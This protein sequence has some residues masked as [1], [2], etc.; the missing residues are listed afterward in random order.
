MLKTSLVLVSMLLLSACHSLN[1]RHDTLAVQCDL[2]G[3]T[4]NRVLIRF[5]NPGGVEL[6]PEQVAQLKVQ[7]QGVSNQ[8]SLTL[9][10]RAC[11]ALPLG[12]AHI[13]A[14]ISGD[15]PL[16]AEIKL[17]ELAATDTIHT[18]ILEAPGV[19]DLELKCPKNG[20]LAASSLENA[21]NVKKSVGKLNGYQVDLDLYNSSNER[22][23]SLFNKALESE[24]LAIPQIFDLKNVEEGNYKV[25]LTVVD[26]Y[27]NK[28]GKAAES[29][30]NLTVRRSCAK[31]ETFDAATISCVP[32]LCD[33]AYRIGAKWTESLALQRGEGR[34]ECRL[35]KEKAHK[36][37]VSHTCQ[38]GYFK[39]A[40][41]CL[42]AREIAGNCALLETDEVVCWGTL[43]GK[44]NYPTNEDVNLQ[45][46]MKFPEKI[47]NF[48]KWCAEMESGKVHCWAL[49]YG[50]DKS[51]RFLPSAE[52]PKTWNAAI[53]GGFVD[54]DEPCDEPAS[55][56]TCKF[57]FTQSGGV[58]AIVP[59]PT[60][61]N[62]S[63]IV[64]IEGKIW[65]YQSNLPKAQPLGSTVTAAPFYR[66]E[67]LPLP[68]RQARSDGFTVCAVLIDGSV[69]CWGDNTTGS[70]GSNT[71][72]LMVN[73]PVYAVESK[74]KKLVDIQEL[75][76]NLDMS[77][78]R[79]TYALAKDGRVFAWGTNL[80][81]TLANG[82]PGEDDEGNPLFSRFAVPVIVDAIN[83]IIYQ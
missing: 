34:Y 79:I 21:V 57:R 49:T 10:S 74:G 31:D 80:E 36:T 14:N 58:N 28:T 37:L 7:Y 20:W 33:S 43:I 27:H 70:V 18:V 67:G 62:A 5:T 48:G 19:L 78:R 41:S 1:N 17:D 75:T 55:D 25:K 63:C 4:Q 52:T 9:T 16:T 76:S 81:G 40:D 23:Q 71:S 51:Y 24:N 64:D 66:V 47:K 35:E 44:E 26:S 46:T 42:G 29:Q 72:E 56:A 59:T 68:A 15:S 2:N 53:K 38:G 61:L 69:M 3:R 50:S 8:Q 54:K 60:G 82:T 32:K 11:V 12:E 13:K 6:T 30:C 77:G 45:T 73:E 22:I 39:S 83:P 65:C